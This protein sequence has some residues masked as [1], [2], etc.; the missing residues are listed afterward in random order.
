MLSGVKMQLLNLTNKQN[1]IKEKMMYLPPMVSLAVLKQCI[2]INAVL[3]YTPV[4]YAVLCGL[5]CH[6]CGACNLG[7]SFRNFS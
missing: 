4:V 2:G 6:E 1:K 7:F 3:Y 5:F